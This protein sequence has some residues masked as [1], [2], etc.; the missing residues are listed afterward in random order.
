MWW[1]IAGLVISIAIALLTPK[2]E[3]PDVK[4]AGLK[5]FTIP[6]V[7]EAR[8]ISVLWGKDVLDGP[9]VIAYGN[10]QSI[11]IEESSGGGLFGGGEDYTV[12]YMYFLDMDFSLC[13]GVLN[14]L[15][16]I[17]FGD[18]VAWSG[19]ITAD[20]SFAVS[21]ITLFGGPPGEGGGVNGT[22]NYYQ[23]TDTQTSDPYLNS[24]LGQQPGNRNVAHMVWKGGYLGDSQYIKPVSFLASRYPNTLGL[25]S[26]KHIIDNEA[27]PACMIYEAYTSKL[28]GKGLDP[29]NIDRTSFQSAGN[30][31]YDEGLGMSMVVDTPQEVEDVIGE[32]LRHIN[33]TVYTDLST[34]KIAI[35]LVRD[36]YVIANIPVLDEDII[37]DVDDFTRG[38]IG[39]IAT[40]IRCTYRDRTQ[41][42]K[43]RVFIQ[44]EVG[45][46]H[47]L[48]YP[49]PTS[50]S[51]LGFTKPGIISK[52]A[53]RE[54]LPLSQVPAS[55]TLIVNRNAYD[56]VPGDPFKMVWSP[57]E[58]SQI[59]MRVKEIDYG[60][61][62][63][64]QIRI[65]CTEDVYAL[66]AAM[67][68]DNPASGW[69]PITG[70]PLDID[71][72]TWVE[73]NYWTAQGASK[74]KWMVFATTPRGDH[75]GFNIF[76]WDGAGTE[77]TDYE[78]LNNLRQRLT[79]PMTLASDFAVDDTEID[80]NYNPRLHPR[81]VTEGNILS[82]GYNMLLLYTSKAK[83]EI[84]GYTGYVDNGDG[85]YTLTGIL[86]GLIDT[87]PLSWEDGDYIYAL[88]GGYGVND[89]TDLSVFTTQYYRLQGVS[90]R[91]EWDIL[92]IGTTEYAQ[93][94]EKRVDAPWPMGRFYIN[95]V[96]FPTSTI[97]TDLVFT[98]AHREKT[99]GTL[100][101]QSDS[102]GTKETNVSYTLEFRN[103]LGSL[104][105]T[106]SGETGVTWTY[107]LASIASDNGGSLPSYLD[108]TAY[109]V[110]SG[111]SLSSLF[112]QLRRV[113]FVDIPTPQTSGSVNFHIEPTNIDSNLTDF[114]VVLYID[115][116][117][118]GIGSDGI[119]LGGMVTGLG[120][121]KKKFKIEDSGSNSL[122]IEVAYWDA[123]FGIAEIHFKAPSISSSSNTTFTISWDN[124]WADNSDVG[125]TGDASA[126]AVWDSDYVFVFHLTQSPTGAG[127]ILDSTSN[128]NDGD[129]NNMDASN[130]SRFGINFNGTDE[131]IDNF[132]AQNLSADDLL[133]TMETSFD[134][135]DTSEFRPLLGTNR[136]IDA[137]RHGYIPVIRN[138]HATNPEK[139]FYNN[140]NYPSGPVY[141]YSINSA[142]AVSTGEVSFVSVVI[143]NAG[144]DFA[145]VINTT[146]ETGLSGFTSG[147]AL[148]DSTAMEIGRRR[149]YT[150][151][152]LYFDGVIYE[153]RWSSIKRSTAWL[154]ATSYN[155]RNS[156]IRETV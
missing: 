86:R 80:I 89:L 34:G 64:G 92:D 12:G 130:Q 141:G 40:E 139:I 15:Y 150:Y 7:S 93:I 127:T 41:N 26:N 116:N 77:I 134:V 79:T 151:G 123:I 143:D 101:K 11:A 112:P 21:N 9:N 45:A 55:C 84:I 75:L 48:G 78:K 137:I 69:V 5:D 10:L 23:G 121:A 133:G 25:T 19:D 118:G 96:E 76:K 87:T 6:T 61:L 90:E 94:I 129:P 104:I 144:D 29:S 142:T 42:Y 114:P 113:Y 37:V 65:S 51:Y 105:K 99:T 107:T 145:F 119:E 81:N 52:I 17:R 44:P 16:E 98:W 128:G 18:Y 30:T 88:A 135:D 53:K 102:T 108:I 146:V 14:H 132:V 28:F 70:E 126:Q 20:A 95:G 154:K 103:E 82:A 32:I 38:S 85:T 54:L 138:T 35:K 22:V 59:I 97:V 4:P 109:A 71:E 24:T 13:W 60:T 72:A 50:L 115:D 58:I 8:N 1:F 36:D 110:D 140:T 3:T 57:L 100:Q 122:K 152:D 46:R 120:T 74:Y 49:K 91:G 67:F 47:Q 148:P 33:A 56:L 39:T 106:Q 2:P 153:M 117:A 31:L 27:N 68:D 131:F 63:E 149:N 125:E 73:M 66:T 43:E 111:N 136:T 124:S 62:V 156:L 83:Q 147:E 155:L